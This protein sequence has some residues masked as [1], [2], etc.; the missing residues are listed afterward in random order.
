MS[1]KLSKKKD[2]VHRMTSALGQTPR[3]R[4][5][6]VASSLTASI[7]T[8]KGRF[9]IWPEWNET[10][11]NSEKWDAGKGIKEK[12]KTGK[13][14]ALHVFDDPEGKIELPADLKIH[15]WKRPHEFITNTSPV[16]VK[17]ETSFD[18]FSANEHLIGSELMR[19][20]ISEVSALWRIFNTRLTNNIL[21]M[22]DPPSFAWK[23]WEHIYALCK[24]V[25]G[26]MPLY[27]S[28]GKYAVKLYW[29]GCWRKIVVDDTLPFSEDNKL[30]LPSTTCEAELWPLLLSK[31]LIK[32]ASVDT[33][34]FEKR[35]HGEFT[36]LHSL[37]GWL[38]EVI[39]LE[40]DYLNKV[41]E[42]LKGTVPEF[43]L[44]DENPESDNAGNEEKVHEINSVEIKADVPVVPV[45]I[46]PQEKTS[47]DFLYYNFLE[48]H[49]YSGNPHPCSG[50]IKMGPE[51]SLLRQRSEN[52]FSWQTHPAISAVHIP[53][54]EK[55][56]AGF[57]SCQ[58][59][60]PGNWEHNQ[61]VFNQTVQQW[62]HSEVDLMES[63][64][65]WKAPFFCTKR[66]DPLVFGM[67]EVSTPWNFYL[68]HFVINQ[69]FDSMALEIKILK[70]GFCEAILQDSMEIF[71][72]LE[73]RSLSNPKDLGKKKG[74]K[75]KNRSGSHSARP[76]SASSNNLPQ[77][78]P[79]HNTVPLFPQMVVYANYLPLNLSEQK[80][81]VLGQMADS[82]ETLRHYGLSHLYNHPVFVTRTRCC[83]L[84]APPKP[85][86]IPRWKLIRQKK[87]VDV[88]DEAK[89]PIKK[90]PDQFIE[91][92]TPFLNFRLNPISVPS[93]GNIV[94]N[95]PRSV[96]L[97]ASS[98]ASVSEIEENAEENNMDIKESP[99]LYDGDATEV[100]SIVKDAQGSTKGTVKHDGVSE[101]V[102][103]DGQEAGMSTSQSLHC[104]EKTQ[105]DKMPE[106]KHASK[107]TWIDFSDFCKCFQTLYVFHKPNTYPYTCQKSE[108]KTTDDQGS[109][110]LCVDNLKS[111]E[112]FVSFSA[113][114]RWGDSPFHVKEEPGLQSGLLTAEQYS[115][116]S[117]QNGPV[118]LKI[119]TDATKASMITLPPGR[120]VL[121][122]TASSPLGHH[123]HLCSTVPFVFGDEETVMPYLDKESYRFMEQ[124]RNI[125]KAIW[126][127]IHNFSN[128][129]E[130][131]QVI[132][133]LRLT[134]YPQQMKASHLR[135]A[136]GHF[137]AFNTALWHLM[138]KAM[139]NKVTHDLI[140]A[141]R[142]FTLDFNVNL[143]SESQPIPD[144]KS[145]VPLS[146]QNR[147]P[148]KLEEAATIK[149]QS[150]WRGIY[151]RKCWRAR[152]AGTTEN[153]SV[154]RTLEKVWT[155]L[156]PNADQY[157][158]SLLR[159]MFKHSPSSH[160]Y[161]S[162]EDESYRISFSDYN[163]LYPDQPA[164]SWFVVFREVFYMPEDMLIVPKV[165]TTI[166]I[167][168]LHVINND[169][170]EEM[171]LVFN[172]VAPHVYTKNKK[173][174]TFIAEAYSGEIAVASGKWRLRLIGACS[175]LPSLSRDTVNNSFSVKEVKDYYI[176]N[177]KDM[178][179]RYRVKTSIEH[180]A[181][182]HVQMCKP[183]VFFKIQILDNDEEVVST[184]GK[185]HAVIPAVCFLPSE[186]PLSSVS[187]KNQR[188]LSGTKKGRITSGGSN[189]NS[190]TRAESVPE[191]Q[192]PA[193]YEISEE[194]TATPLPMHKYIIQAT[195]LHKS[196]PLTE[197]QA[198]FVES[199]R[200]MEKQEGKDKHEETAD[201]PNT[202]EGQ[203]ASATPKA[204]R[205]VK[206]KT[207]EKPE[208]EKSGKERYQSSPSSRPES[209]AQQHTESNKPFWIMRL[210]S[211]ASE[212]DTLEVKKDTE[213]ID[214]IRSMKQAWELAEPG[215]AVKALQSRLQ[216]INK[217]TQ[218]VPVGQT[219][220]TIASEDFNGE[221]TVPST[222]VLEPK[223]IDPSEQ[224]IS[225]ELQPLDL[226]PLIRSTR[227]QP[228]LRDELMIQQQAEQKAEEIRQF[229]QLREEVLAHREQEQ[230]ARILLKKKVLQIYEDLQLSLDAAR[231]K[232]LGAR[233]SYRIKM[234]EAEN[235]KQE[236][237]T[238]QDTSPHTEQEKRNISAQ[239]RKSG[240]S[241][242][243][244]K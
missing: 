127:V 45:I 89:E 194:K 32:L 63:H 137:Q 186:R 168:I 176:P 157:G 66:K 203:K 43:K 122:F 61:I 77:C 72:L 178:I 225:K 82:S 227:S 215:R 198:T 155:A 98:L 232:I 86:P 107:E 100:S 88:T 2:S 135:L 202:T 120:H 93:Q 75:E 160:E 67:D 185:G 40:N 201:V 211:E 114:V 18:L 179:F 231:E 180:T 64:D 190:K 70:K 205:K 233:E 133:E 74:E 197:S 139:G 158:V 10:D 162:Y 23:P 183:D 209:R 17:D 22:M 138:T 53:G 99:G 240:K 102:V 145:E 235:K 76:P 204:A 119:H 28:Y 212:A 27:N 219:T 196:W 52:F 123:I 26:H 106:M 154:K 207:T 171:P 163:T 148:T 79:D 91:I 192:N 149:L 239:K 81:S 237:I 181:T 191:I 87:E 62:G 223:S 167:C 184:T 92:T 13:S 96:S 222:K 134:H 208:K 30:L 210:V 4:P 14:P 187:S 128:E 220:Q 217:Y 242:G 189:K 12:E 113:L 177:N 150:C 60:D 46:K 169:T 112:I 124:A 97:V 21:T 109:Y 226:T 95:T 5:S 90:K 80:I 101:N 165:Y 33:N 116:K 213:R 156:E 49:S 218:K 234:L 115:W 121:R 182:I 56:V 136:K 193:E 37:T 195:V 57:L 65:S 78:L 104:I 38:P 7:E 69:C 243:R 199:L 206:E 84:V 41:W 230:N 19:W 73:S 48:G 1:S 50:D 39:P 151:V 140:F 144:T 36:V 216:Y 3:D 153:T 42:F 44:P 85:P 34:G 68:V 244:K 241:S 125:I 111:T 35:E 143:S 146:W 170:M 118:V 83:P 47:K 131:I 117:L 29:M 20:I 16:V 175:P 15:S 126:K 224:I 214:E 236:A 161:S 141:F 229:R 110:Y 105:E 6:F 188:L 9:S 59:V 103:Q 172:K 55:V 221:E 132:K 8:K 166:P 11:I 129:I 58:H 130:F 159:Y 147:N 174:Y 142:V 31:A 94:H 54:V 51:A 24:A 238:S 71:S 228:T 164:N 200:E 173:G 152:K 25:K 108:F